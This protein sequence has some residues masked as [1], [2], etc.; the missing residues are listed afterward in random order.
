M[1][2]NIK[3][4]VFIVF[5]FSFKA[6]SI[7]EKEIQEFVRKHAQIMR[8]T[9]REASH[10]SRLE[11]ALVRLRELEA[12]ARRDRSNLAP[13]AHRMLA[14]AEQHVQAQ[15]QRVSLQQQAQQAG[16]ALHSGERNGD[17]LAWA[18]GVLTARR[19]ESN[20]SLVHHDQ[21]SNAPSELSVA[22]SWISQA[23]TRLTRQSAFS[24]R[25]FAESDLWTTLL[26]DLGQ[27]TD[28]VLRGALIDVVRHFAGNSESRQRT[29]ATYGQAVVN[30]QAAQAVQEAV[31]QQ[32][33]FAWA[34]ARVLAFVG[35][36]TGLRRTQADLREF[37]N[38][39]RRINVMLEYLNQYF[40]S[41]RSGFAGR[42]Q[43]LFVSIQNNVAVTE[44]IERA[45]PAPRTVAQRR[46][47]NADT[48]SSEVPQP[49]N[50]AAQFPD[51]FIEAIRAENWA[52]LDE[53]F[54][55]QLIL[56][57]Y[58]AAG[59]PCMPPRLRGFLNRSGRQIS[60]PG[61]AYVSAAP[62]VVANVQSS[63]AASARQ[64]E[65]EVSAVRHQVALSTVLNPVQPP[66]EGQYPTVAQFGYG[67]V[68]V[69]A[70]ENRGRGH[71]F[72]EATGIT[73]EDFVVNGSQ[74]LHNPEVR[75]FF[76]GNSES[77]E[78]NYGQWAG[79]LLTNL[80]AN[81]EHLEIFRAIYGQL[82]IMVPRNG[83]WVPQQGQP[84]I[85]WTHRVFV[86]GYVGDGEAGHYVQLRQ[87]PLALP[88]AIQQ[89][90][91]PYVAASYEPPQIVNHYNAE[92]QALPQ[93]LYQALLDRGIRVVGVIGMLALEYLQRSQSRG[94]S[95]DK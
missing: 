93:A 69:Q 23:S 71:C 64:S 81:G 21:E 54:S 44:A 94:S 40:E 59:T 83:Q 4:F 63:A 62:R 32:A 90:N 72:F 1:S 82:L 43:A 22:R 11:E 75:R 9:A 5:I 85:D 8:A 65:Q 58:N 36:A 15:R 55:T 14:E 3:S 52:R 33:L 95:S 28:G 79:D 24:I 12:V 19:T 66:R 49:S 88:V 25:Q 76:E 47:R 51:G 16:N 48:S 73:V 41:R 61:G 77:I 34:E 20:P 50:S 74:N 87:V 68:E 31:N 35:M 29:L 53:Q 89:G 86:V 91:M 27:L 18:D 60:G 17:I 80:G 78:A 6:F 7:S 67:P 37:A 30:E 84:A 45:N 38:Q 10:V 39:N 92:R 2:F 46:Q 57:Y 70:I 26:N 56:D 13:E 42:I